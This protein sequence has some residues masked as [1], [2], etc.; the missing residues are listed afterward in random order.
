MSNPMRSFQVFTLVLLLGSFA[1]IAAQA[2]E[3]SFLNNPSRVEINN[4]TSSE[5]TAGE[6]L[7]IKYDQSRST[8]CSSSNR[9]YQ[10][11]LTASYRFDGGQIHTVMLP[12]GETMSRFSVFVPKGTLLLRVWFY[13]YTLASPNSPPVCEAYDSDFG[14][15]FKFKIA[16]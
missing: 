9:M 11:F 4:G 10:S 1:S 6:N 5:I 16:E 7:I 14:Q 15:D 2:S 8:T 3:I 12:N 13:N